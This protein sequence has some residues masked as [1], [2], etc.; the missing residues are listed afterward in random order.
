MCV[1]YSRLKKGSAG[2]V[3]CLVRIGSHSME[4]YFYSV[5]CGLYTSIYTYTLTICTVLS[6]CYW[7]FKEIHTPLLL[8]KNTL[9]PWT[10]SIALGPSCHLRSRGERRNDRRRS[11]CLV[12]QK[13]KPKT[14]KQSKNRKNERLKKNTNARFVGKGRSVK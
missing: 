7:I 1:K 13:T 5:L 2:S 11:R 14:K 3:T 4:L 9:Q 6:F 12:I 10:F 8:R